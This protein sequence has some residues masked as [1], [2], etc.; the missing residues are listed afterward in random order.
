MDWPACLL[1]LL[2]WAKAAVA[3]GRRSL[4]GENKRPKRRKEGVGLS[5]EEERNR[6]G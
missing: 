3:V 4:A 5:L 6:L 1:G 2:S